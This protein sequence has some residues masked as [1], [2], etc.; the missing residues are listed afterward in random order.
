MTVDINYFTIN[1]CVS[2]LHQ[3]RNPWVC[4]QTSM[5]PTVLRGPGRI[6]MYSFL[7][8]YNHYVNK[9]SFCV[10]IRDLKFDQ[11]HYILHSLDINLQVETRMTKV[12]HNI[13]KW[14][15]MSSKM[16]AEHAHFTYI[17]QLS[18]YTNFVLK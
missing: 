16:A 11:V 15:M 13:I 8:I 4:S 12:T 10:L 9:H 7:Y 3:T 5:L 17:F 6:G 14:S 2:K 18:L 1:L